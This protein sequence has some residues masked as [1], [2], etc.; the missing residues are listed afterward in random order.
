[1][2]CDNAKK[3]H[4]IAFFLKKK[5]TGKII[6][7]SLFC[8]HIRIAL[9]ALVCIFFSLGTNVK[10]IGVENVYDA[11]PKTR[12]NFLATANKILAPHGYKQVD[13]LGIDY[14]FMK[15]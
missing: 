6:D 1:M 14:I 4:R 9:P 11:Q 2:R 13:Q 3:S 15:I 8:I 7:R 12:T 10:L 5:K